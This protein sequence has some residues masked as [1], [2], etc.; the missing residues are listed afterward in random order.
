MKHI[1]KQSQAGDD[2]LVSVT[3]GGWLAG[4]LGRVAREGCCEGGEGTLSGDSLRGEQKSPDVGLS[5]EHY[6]L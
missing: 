5:W 1:L 3:Q 2:M 6:K 4:Y